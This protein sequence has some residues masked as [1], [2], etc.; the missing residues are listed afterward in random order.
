MQNGNILFIR[1]AEYLKPV[2]GAYY[3]QSDLPL[4]PAGEAQARCLPEL[5]ARLGLNIGR[6]ISSDLMRARRT[7]ELALPGVDIEFDAGLRETSF[8]A[9]EGLKYA[10]VCGLP[11]FAEYAS[12]GAPPGGEAAAAVERRV[13]AALERM[14]RDCADGDV[15]I[16]AHAGPIRLMLAQL[17][18][19]PPGDNWRFKVDMASLSVVTLTEGYAYISALNAGPWLLGQSTAT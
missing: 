2:P 19:L 15:A 3:G 16:V 4:T 5:I 13:A 11:E 8:G 1:H 6:A 18:G 14:L 9:W 12:G 17:L 7:A 10:D